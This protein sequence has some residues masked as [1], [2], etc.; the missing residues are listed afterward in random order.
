MWAWPFVLSWDDPI[1]RVAAESERKG[2]P[3]L[4]PLIGQ[5]V[6]LNEM[7][8]FGRWWEGIR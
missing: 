3:L 5:K 4:H 2:M 6:N 7:E 8:V 1:I